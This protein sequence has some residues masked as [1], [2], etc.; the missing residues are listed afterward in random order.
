MIANY[1]I[2]AGGK[3]LRPV[4]TILSTKLFGYQGQ[5]HIKIAAAVELIHT[6]T[7]LHDDIIDESKTRRGQITANEKWGN[8]YAVLVGDF[9]FSQ[10]FKLMVATSSIEILDILSSSSSIIAEGEIK[11]L[12]NVGN[13][14]ITEEEYIDVVV[15]KTAE[16]FAAACKSGAVIARQDSIVQNKMYLFG[17]YLGIAFQIIDD[18][19]DYTSTG[20]GKDIGNDFKE[21]KVTLPIIFAYK[22]ALEADRQYIKKIFRSN[23]FEQLDSFSTLVNLL[24][25]YDCFN[26][27]KQVA[28]RFVEQA[29]ACL[30]SVPKNQKFTDIFNEIL[31]Y[32][33]NRVS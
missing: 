5:D 12:N 22:N 17:K 9:L 32:Q 14:G 19:L 28:I 16:L 10:S 30:D 3:R 26:Q 29:R 11:Q 33:V 25:Q 20:T 31:D 1:M 13:I 27:S 23:S 8:K 21:K 15:A 4:F 7:L 18:I 6:A 24:R 2:S